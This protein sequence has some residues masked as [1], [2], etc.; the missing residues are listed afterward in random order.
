M[1]FHYLLRAGLIL[2]HFRSLP[3]LAFILAKQEKWWSAFYINLCQIR[4]Q[5]QGQIK[6]EV[7]FPSQPIHWKHAATPAWVISFVES[8]DK[9]AT[10]Y[11]TILDIQTFCEQLW[12]LCC[13]Q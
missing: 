12:L 2:Y 4:T 1:C 6:D 5:C 9:E 13:L 7:Q 3:W 8:P 11:L 10:P